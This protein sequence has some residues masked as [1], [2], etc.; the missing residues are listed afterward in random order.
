[1]TSNVTLN[2]GFPNCWLWD[3]GEGVPTNNSLS[4]SDVKKAIITITTANIYPTGMCV[5]EDEDL[6]KS[7]QGLAHNTLCR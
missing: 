5:C 6:T 1:M 4:Y 7:P 3:L 2:S